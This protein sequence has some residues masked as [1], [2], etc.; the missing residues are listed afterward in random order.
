MKK[1][2][3]LTYFGGL[4]CGTNLQA[5]ASLCAVRSVLPNH[6]VEIVPY[7]SFRRSSR[8]Y[9]SNATLR[10]LLGDMRRIASYRLFVREHLEV[11]KVF[12]S[13]DY[14]DATDWITA[15]KYDAILVG[16]DTV[17]ELHRSELRNLPEDELTAYWLS[18]EINAHKVLLAGSAKSETIGEL[19]E[20]RCAAARASLRE[21]SWLGPRDFPTK[22]LI[23]GLSP[24]RNGRT[25]VV[26]D[27]TFS[28]DIDFTSC[29]SYLSKRAISF[30]RPIVCFHHLRKDVWA[31]GVAKLFRQAGYLIAS[32]R[33][34]TFADFHFNDLS[35]MEQ[36]GL[37]RRFA[38]VVTHRF[39]DTIF[40]LKSG[41]A[42]LTYPASKEVVDDVGDSK[43]ASLLRDFGLESTNFVEDIDAL[44][45]NDIFE[46][47]MAA[48]I[49]FNAARDSVGVKVKE[50]ASAYV[51][52]VR[53]ATNSLN[54]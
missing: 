14:S 6:V 19:T 5:Y 46:R 12:V 22:R 29:E 3:V 7:S 20:R 35:P 42:M 52:F 2:G 31:E 15:R 4:N 8:P 54:A 40:C 25:E 9:L 34:T 18:P 28:L 27:P 50:C 21:F 17:W 53:R 30:E 26:P 47:G 49:A 13:L 33:P 37:Y 39:H 10:T 16:A 45:E 48:I 1:I 38:L 24:E 51:D 43:Y 36:L 41:S 44:S 11:K 23:E 32:F